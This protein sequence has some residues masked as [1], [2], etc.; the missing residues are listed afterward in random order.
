MTVAHWIKP[1]H[2]SRVPRRWII[3]DTEAVQA[4]SDDMRVQT[5]RLGVTSFDR[6]DTDDH[7]WTATQWATHQTPEDLWRWVDKRTRRRARTVLVAHNLGYDL[8]ISRALDLLPTLGWSV[9]RMAVHERSISMTWRRDDRSLVLA[10]SMGWLPMSLERIGGMTGQRKHDLPGWGDC[11]ESWEARC[12]RDVAILRHAVLDLVAWVEHGDLGNWQRSGAGQA[13]AHWRHRHY[14]HRV[15]AHDNEAARSAELSAMHTAR[16]EAWRH[17]RLGGDWWEEWDLPLAYPNVARDVDV[18]TALH[19]YRVRP[20]WEW[21]ARAM[22]QRR[23]LVKATVSTSV[24]VLPCNIDGRALWPVGTFSGV[25][26]YVE[27]NEAMSAGAAVVPESAWTYLAAPA[28][29]SWATWVIDAST[30]FDATGSLVRM[31][32]A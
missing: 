7:H 32:A 22:R 8:R 5:W 3:L 9:H 29:A 25:W 16:C 13:W 24:P 11:D 30:R 12:A 1:N 19:S 17:G 4:E 20:S 31:A 15:L 18:P 2:T 23:V 14:T 28:L 6:C 26:W 21:V 27:L 10:D